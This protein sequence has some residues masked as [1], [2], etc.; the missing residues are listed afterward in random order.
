MSP[1]RS[2]ILEA[3][4]RLATGYEELKQLHLRGLS[5]TGSLPQGQ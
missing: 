3:K 4:A 5:G 2:G 1:L